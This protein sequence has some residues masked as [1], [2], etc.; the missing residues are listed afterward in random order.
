[1]GGEGGR[2]V[3]LEPAIEW[4]RAGSA[5]AGLPKDVV[6]GHRGA[7]ASKR[8]LGL[9]LC[10]LRVTGAQLHQHGA[11]AQWDPVPHAVL[12]HVNVV[13][14]ELAA[15]IRHRDLH[16]CHRSGDVVGNVDRPVFRHAG[17]VGAVDG[18]GPAWIFVKVHVVTPQEG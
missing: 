7:V 9:R 15:R 11:L 13:G 8:R 5:A 1:M 18:C 14:I 10:G 16:R 12:P 17:C 6:E 4:A 2:H 3:V